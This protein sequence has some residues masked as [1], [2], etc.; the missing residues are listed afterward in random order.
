MYEQRKRFKKK[1]QG[2]LREKKHITYDYLS[3]EDAGDALW[4]VSFWVG[5]P[6]ELFTFP[7]LKA[8]QESWVQDVLQYL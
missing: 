2:R 3:D 5:R 8:L 4:V 1:K 7:L 6:K